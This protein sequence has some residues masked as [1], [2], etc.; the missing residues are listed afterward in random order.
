LDEQDDERVSAMYSLQ[1]LRSR[2][3]RVKHW[4]ETQGKGSSISPL[5][6]EV[7]KMIL[8]AEKEIK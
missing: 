1:N 5:D 6:L 3:D 2:I 8:D 7:Q 4:L